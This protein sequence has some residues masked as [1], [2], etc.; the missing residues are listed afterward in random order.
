VVQ[1]RGLIGL[2]LPTAS[3]MKTPN[4]R[5]K[6]RRLE[7]RNYPQEYK[8]RFVA[9]QQAANPQSDEGNDSSANGSSSSGNNLDSYEGSGNEATSSPT[10]VQLW[11]FPIGRDNNFAE[12]R[13]VLVANLMSRFP[14][15]MRAIIAKEI[16]CSAVKLSISLPFPCLITQL[17][18]EAHIPIL[19]RIDVETYATKKYDLEKSKDE[20][21]YDFKLHKPI[22]EVFRPSGQ[23]ARETETTTKPA[24]ETTGAELVCHA[25]PIHT[26]TPF[27]SS[28][29]AT[30]PRGK[31]MY[32]EF[33]ALSGLKL[34]K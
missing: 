14:L 10:V 4:L 5:E 20:S 33:I 31:L 7:L 11:L 25:A 23:I 1:E 15:N 26:S 9:R 12:D 22:L 21:K 19:V 34:R 28:A 16:M 6:N 2:K 13:A 3:E 27:T 30:Q 29:A 32:C 24:G 18:R 8:T 17:C